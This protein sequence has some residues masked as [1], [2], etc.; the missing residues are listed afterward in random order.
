MSTK[1]AQVAKKPNKRNKNQLPAKEKHRLFDLYITPH[2]ADVKSLTKQYTNHYQDV[3]ENYNHCLAQLYNYIG[4]YNPDMK[5]FTW[6]HIVVKRACYHQNQKRSEEASHWTDIE[7]CT[8]EDLYR[9]G[10]S[11]MTEASFG[12]LLDNLSDHLVTS[13]M[14]IDPLK[15]SPFMLSVQG[16]GIREITAMEW[17]RGHLEKKSEDMVKSRIYW[18]RKE[19]LY[20]LRKYGITRTNY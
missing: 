12:N 15:L 6:I 19:L 11:L 13:L 17:Q 10:N 16:H 5:L 14:S 4:T 18:A 20:H 7:M 2:L 9:P 1:K 8:P 3:E